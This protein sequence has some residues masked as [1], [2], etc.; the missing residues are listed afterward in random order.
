MRTLTAAQLQKLF[1][2]LPAS[3]AAL[4]AQPFSDAL[5]NANIN[6]RSRVCAFVAQ[7][8][9]E[10]NDLKFLREIWGP[11]PAQTRYDVRTDLGNTPER[12][13]DGKRFMGRGGLQRT[14]AKN[15]QRFKDATGID[16]IAHPELLELPA[17]AF[18]SDALFWTDNKLNKLADQLTL[19]GDHSDLAK[20]DQITRKIN[21]GYNGQV[22]RQRRYL[23]AIATLDP[24]L[25]EPESKVEEPSTLDQV[26]A[27]VNPPAVEPPVDHSKILFE[28]LAAHEGA[29]NAAKSLGTRL[30]RPGAVL[31]SALATGNKYVGLRRSSWPLRSS[32]TS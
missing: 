24:S 2:Q 26:N 25:F 9:H 5:N 31:L 17:Y 18:Q 10:S 16:V 21:G 7:V 11:T 6:T 15:Y 30:L 32:G 27:H 4:Y 20:L 23:V 22:D 3:K 28:K 1:P 8:G 12:D 19:R 14:G 13:G 29:Q